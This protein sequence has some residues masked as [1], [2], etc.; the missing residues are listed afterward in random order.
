MQAGDLEV[1]SDGPRAGGA[2]GVA[3]RTWVLPV[4]RV[5][6]GGDGCGYI[7][8]PREEQAKTMEDIPVRCR[9]VN[10]DVSKQD[11]LQVKTVLNSTVK[12]VTLLAEGDVG[13][14]RWVVS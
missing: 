5:L 6:A 4:R 13:V 2:E 1:S 12:T 8:I 10:V 9:S 3:S 11:M 7:D 14:S